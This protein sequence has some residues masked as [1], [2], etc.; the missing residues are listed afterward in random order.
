MKNRAAII[1]SALAAVFLSFTLGF[2][3]GRNA[4]GGNVTTTRVVRETLPAE[5]VY[6]TV[7]VVQYLPPETAASEL[8]TESAPPEQTAPIGTGSAV[9]SGS[10][11]MAED[12]APETRATVPTE[13][14]PPETQAPTEP[15]APKE[16]KPPVSFPINVNTASLEELMELP[17]IGEVIGQ[18]IIDYRNTYGPFQ[19]LEELMNV[20]GIGEKRL[21][22]LRTYATVGG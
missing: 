4:G 14:T 1:L 21:E 8:P 9:P 19:T 12:P 15:P 16:T 5:T 11:A 6:V 10:G 2:F 13:E 18:R 20:S 17:G 22:N 7:P 3:L